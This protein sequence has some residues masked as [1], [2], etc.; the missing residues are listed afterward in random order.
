MAVCETVSMV[1]GTWEECMPVPASLLAARLL[2]SSRVASDGSV[3]H[4]KSPWPEVVLESKAD[5]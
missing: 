4:M 5:L 2:S 3:G 1:V